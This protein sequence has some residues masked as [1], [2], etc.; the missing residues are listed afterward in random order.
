MLTIN[1]TAHPQDASQVEAVKAFLKALKINF[2]VTKQEDDDVF[3]PEMQSSLNQVQQIKTGKLP[4]QS[5]KEF[6]DEL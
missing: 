3:I 6:L 1:I 5:A 2:E 4:K